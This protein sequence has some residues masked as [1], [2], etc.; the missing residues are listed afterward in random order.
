MDLT[1]GKTGHAVKE[2]HGRRAFSDQANES[3]RCRQSGVRSRPRCRWGNPQPTGAE[4]RCTQVSVSPR[5]SFLRRCA[6]LER[7]EETGIGWA[8]LKGRVGGKESG[9]CETAFI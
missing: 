4:N 2:A 9:F 5:D 3:T 6:S 8:P 1:G 7:H